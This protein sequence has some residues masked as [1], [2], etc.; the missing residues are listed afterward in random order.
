M[1]FKNNHSKLCVQ[2]SLKSKKG[3]SKNNVTQRK[4]DFSQF[5]NW[6]PR[7]SFMD[8]PYQTSKTQNLNLKIV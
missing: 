8:S 7:T 5:K 6:F 4:L 3:L 2:T 1:F